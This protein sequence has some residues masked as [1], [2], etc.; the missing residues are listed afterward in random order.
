MVIEYPFEQSSPAHAR[1]RALR[2]SVFAGGLGGTL[3]RSGNDLT[4]Q[5]GVGRQNA[6]VVADQE[7]YP[8]TEQLN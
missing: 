5:L 7:T 4:A 6:M 2:L 1:R 8:I 3:C